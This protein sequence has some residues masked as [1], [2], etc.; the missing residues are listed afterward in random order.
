MK[1][2][3]VKALALIVIVIF[4]VWLGFFVGI[5]LALKTLLIVMT[6]D[7]LTGLALALMGNSKHGDGNLSSKIGYKGL[8]KK[9]T[10]LLLV[11]LC[12][13]M[14][15]Y[16]ASYGISFQYLKDISIIAFII[17]EIISIIENARLSGLEIPEVFTRLIEFLKS[18]KIKK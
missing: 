2:N 15:E 14:E 6:I 4:T 11:G 8:V 5:D 1:N 10:V 17:N 9:V 3:L 13:I 18:M 16:L 7:Y 12:A